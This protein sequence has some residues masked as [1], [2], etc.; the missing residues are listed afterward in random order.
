MVQWSTE[1][2]TWVSQ[3]DEA[4][5]TLFIFPYTATSCALVQYHTWA[6][7]RAPEA[8]E[9]LKLIQETATR[10]EQTVQPGTFSPQ[11]CEQS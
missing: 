2:I 1:S 9:M 5:D 8:L 4:L 7:R 6:R 10:W 3:N 11:S